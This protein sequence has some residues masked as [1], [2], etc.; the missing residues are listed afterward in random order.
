M[1]FIGLQVFDSSF[2]SN[3]KCL[4]TVVK[5]KLKEYEKE[6]NLLQTMLNE[7]INEKD[8]QKN[9]KFWLF[10]KESSEFW[11]HSQSNTSLESLIEIRRKWDAY[12]RNNEKMKG[13][14]EEF[15]GNIPIYWVRPPETPSENWSKYS[16][17]REG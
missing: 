14:E 17:K 12:I 9:L 11:F 2:D 10:G 5:D 3:L 13:E 6:Q 7:K 8:Y 16:V 4:Q 15:G 1:Q